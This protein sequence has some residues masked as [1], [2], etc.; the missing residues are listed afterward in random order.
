MDEVITF[1]KSLKQ[2]LEEYNEV[3][4][5]EF[6]PSSYIRKDWIFFLEMVVDVNGWQALWKIPRLTCEKLEIPFPSVVLVLILNVEFKS[7]NALVR[8]LAVQDEIMIPEKNVVSLLQL[9]PTKEQD[10]SIALNIFSTANAL[11]M[12][13]FFYLHVYMPWDRDEDDNIDWKSNHLESRLRLYYDMKNGSIPRQ[14]AEH[15]HSLLTTARR[16]Q[17]QRE[18]IEEQLKEYGME[19]GNVYFSSPLFLYLYE[20][21]SLK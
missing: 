1:D 20:I 18:V 10:K 12:Y 13:R 14:I 2:R 8:V 16:L 19:N 4:S 15:I 9:W 11:D 5:V 7:L 3:F 6:L 17:N 21:I